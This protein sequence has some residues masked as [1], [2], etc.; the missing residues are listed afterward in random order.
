M[1]WKTF[2]FYLFLFF[3]STSVSAHG[4]PNQIIMNPD[5]F[6]PDIIQIDKGETVIFT[7]EDTRDRWPASNIHPTHELYPQFDPQRPIKRADSWTFKFDRAGEWKYH[8]HLIP[9]LKGSIKVIGDN[10]T[11]YSLWSRITSFLG[12]IFNNVKKNLPSKGPPEDLN[13]FVREQLSPCYQT[14]GRDGCYKKAARVLY[15]SLGLSKTL[16]LLKEN[17]NYT[18]VYVRCHEVTHY[19]SR[20]EYEKQKSIPEAYSQCDSTCHGGCYHGVL[21]AYL[22]ESFDH[23]QDKKEN[24]LADLFPKICGVK[25]DYQKPIEFYECLHGLGHAAMFVKEM[26]LRESLALCDTLSDQGFRERCYTG[27]F[28]ENSSSSTSNDHPAIY[29]RADDPFYPCNSM[30]EKYLPLCWQY[31]SSYFSILNQQN[32]KKVAQMCL[33]IPEKYQEKCFRTIGTNQVGFTSSL[34]RMKD[35]CNLMPDGHFRDI[36]VAGVVSSLAYRFVGE[37]QKMIDFCSLADPQNQE[38]C[39][40]QMGTALLDWSTDKELAKSQCSKIPDQKLANWCLS[41]I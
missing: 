17:E 36:C 22:K 16:K 9:K 33:Q 10:S 12:L 39:F 13:A 20:F 8:D 25:K 31:Q 34:Q 41:A 5:G 37:S 29:V 14:D 24:F 1:V 19:L 40:K 26:E 30:E 7:N 6:D 4:A 21:E 18:E 23:A 11:N 35:D 32:W 3:C 38:T 28:M 2:I 27:V 15:D